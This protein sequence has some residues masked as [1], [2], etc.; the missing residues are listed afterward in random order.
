MFLFCTFLCRL[1][2]TSFPCLPCKE[3][4]LMTSSCLRITRILSWKENIR[5][6]PN[7]FRTVT[8]SPTVMR[9]TWTY[10]PG[11]RG[12]QY[13][14]KNRFVCT[15]KKVSVLLVSVLFFSTL[16]ILAGDS[17][18]VQFDSN[19]TPKVIRTPIGCYLKTADRQG[20]FALMEEDDLEKRRM[21]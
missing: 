9:T 20:N 16:L 18:T 21:R 11:H 8:A 17:T 1:T 19:F 7:Q 5:I 13:T 15:M 14:N 2:T 12:F 10:H 3:A 4:A 6:K